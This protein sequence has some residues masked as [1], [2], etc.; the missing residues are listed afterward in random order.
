MKEGFNL[1]WTEKRQVGF[2][3]YFSYNINIMWVILLRKEEE[4]KS[5]KK[6]SK[7]VNLINP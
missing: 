3:K 7:K 5:T 4:T 2:C 6:C 1:G